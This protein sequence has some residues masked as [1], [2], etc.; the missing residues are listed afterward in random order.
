MCRS[1]AL[2]GAGCWFLPYFGTLVS[3]TNALYNNS[4]VQAFHITGSE[5]TTYKC[6]RIGCS[7][8]ASGV[9]VMFQLHSAWQLP[10]DES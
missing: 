3:G 1:L 2:N 4:V 8:L 7:A 5:E 6:S 9:G 10:C